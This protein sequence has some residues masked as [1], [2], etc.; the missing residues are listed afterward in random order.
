MKHKSV[1]AALQFIHTAANNYC[2]YYVPF[3]SEPIAFSKRAH[4]KMKAVKQTQFYD[5]NLL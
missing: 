4:R 1:L 5:S 2:Q 3:C